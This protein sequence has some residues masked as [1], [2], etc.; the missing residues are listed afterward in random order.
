MTRQMTLWY[1]KDQALFDPMPKDHHSL[2]VVR[3]PGG[4]VHSLLSFHC[5]PRTKLIIGKDVFFVAAP[6]IWNQ[7]HVAIKSPLAVSEVELSRIA[8]LLKC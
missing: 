7:V 6:N 4:S 3:I 8:V 5:I 2:E 1:S